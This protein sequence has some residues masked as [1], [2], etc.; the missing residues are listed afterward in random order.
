MNTNLIRLTMLLVALATVGCASV[1]VPQA[2]GGSRADGV[3]EMSYQFGMFESPRVNWGEAQSSA[4]ARCRAWGYT[5]AEAFGGAL[6][7]C[8]STNGYGNCIQTL[9]TMKY[10]CINPGEAVAAP[11]TEDR[12]TV[13]KVRTGSP[14]RDTSR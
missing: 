9:V 7:Q 2:T 8:Q 5:T 10:Q 14:E 6:N 11:A 13:E 12:G 4:A 1:K 3:V